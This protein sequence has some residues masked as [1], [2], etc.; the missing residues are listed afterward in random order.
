MFDLE[1]QVHLDKSQI[2]GT[3]WTVRRSISLFRGAF[4]PPA[5]SGLV[6]HNITTINIVMPAR[7][8]FAQA[9]HFLGVGLRV[10]SSCLR[11]L[12]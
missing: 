6:V 11:N 4:K 2:C 12:L 9:R 1:Q 5:I 3:A 8:A 7:T 10:G